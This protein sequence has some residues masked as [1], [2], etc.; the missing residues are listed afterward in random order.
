[1]YF[2]DDIELNKRKVRRYFPSDESIND[3]RPY[4]NDEIQRIRSVCDL[5][6]KAMVLLMGS[7]GVRI[8]ALSSMQIGHLTLVTFN[9]LTVYKIQVYAGTRDRYITFCTPE[10]YSVIHDEYL[11]C[12]KRCGEQIKDKS[13]LFR[14]DFNKHGPFTINV[15]KFLSD[16]A[17]MKA[18]DECLKKSGVKTTEAMR[19]RAFR[20]GFKSICEQSGMKSINVEMLLGTAFR[21]KHFLYIGPKDHD[22]G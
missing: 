4:T 14:K 12:R 11:D 8:C 22:N 6:S 17:V 15:P 10:C 13:P 20:K 1:M 9:G 7:S 21:T 5:R 19:S 2:L 16:G 18:V 3:D